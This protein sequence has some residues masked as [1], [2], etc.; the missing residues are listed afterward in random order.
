MSN[1]PLI[2]NLGKNLTEYRAQTADV[3]TFTTLVNQHFPADLVLG[4]KPDCVNEPTSLL[5][6][7]GSYL[8]RA[9]I[10]TEGQL[11]Q[12]SIHRVYCPHCRQTWTVYPCIL[13]PGKHYDAYV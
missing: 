2:L 7:H 5:K 9:V 6:Y 11:H 10:D 3:R 4:H 1:I 13:V 12:V 8:R